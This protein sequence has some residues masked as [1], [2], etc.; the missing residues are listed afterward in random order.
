MNNLAAFLMR[1]PK[2]FEALKLGKHPQRQPTIA[3]PLRDLIETIPPALRYEF[4][5][6]RL[7]PDLG[8]NSSARFDNLQQLYTWLGGGVRSYDPRSN[9]LPYVHWRDACFSKKLTIED[10]KPFCER[11]PFYQRCR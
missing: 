11:F 9:S 2:A 7:H 10:L 6:I 3:T 5:G 1:N 4:K 8:F